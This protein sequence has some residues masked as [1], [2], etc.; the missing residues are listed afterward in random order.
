MSNSPLAL[1][2]DLPS[3][4][5]SITLAEKARMKVNCR[6]PADRRPDQDPRYYP[7]R[8]TV[9]VAHWFSDWEAKLSGLELAAGMVRSSG[10]L[11]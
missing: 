4:A 5:F 11:R 9:N 8:P 7:R 3:C 10:S 2:Q 6:F 1:A